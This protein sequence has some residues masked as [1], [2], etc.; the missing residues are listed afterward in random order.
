MKLKDIDVGM[1]LIGAG[2]FA[3]KY[4]VVKKRKKS[5]DVELRT[6]SKVMKGGKMVDEVFLYEKM[7]AKY[8]RGVEDV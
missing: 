2:T 1:T 6:G 5:I 7:K 3:L 4:K 8:F